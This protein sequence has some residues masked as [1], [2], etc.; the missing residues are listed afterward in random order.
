M[1]KNDASI[2]LVEDEKSDEIL[3]IRSL[4]SSNVKEKIY[5]AKDGEE[6]IH[7]LTDKTPDGQAY[8]HPLPIVV[9]LDL[10]L[11]KIGGRDVLH[12]IRLH[13]RTKLV[14]VIIL[15]SSEEEDDLIKC[16]SFGANSYIQKPVDFEEFSSVIRQIGTYWLLLN[17]SPYIHNG[18]TDY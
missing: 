4:R 10:K 1:N 11:P 3:T 13:E 16:Y 17:K 8:L 9:I 12:Q 2:L 5:V 15:S 14:P 6:A 7:H 18:R